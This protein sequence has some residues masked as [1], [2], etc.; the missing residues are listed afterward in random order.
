MGK[1][2]NIGLLGMVLSA[3]GM[4]SVGRAKEAILARTESVCKS[5]KH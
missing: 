5:R 4:P 3:A 2:L 1:Q